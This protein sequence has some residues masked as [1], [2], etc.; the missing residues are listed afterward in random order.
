MKPKTRV[1]K[2]LELEL[3]ER[4]YDPSSP[5]SGLRA[6]DLW[7]E[8]SWLYQ[9]QCK[10]QDHDPKY[11]FDAEFVE[12]WDQAQELYPKIILKPLN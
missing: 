3:A 11:Q 2:F 6:V 10:T 7:C 1:R 8:L 9:E 4:G 5:P 12:F